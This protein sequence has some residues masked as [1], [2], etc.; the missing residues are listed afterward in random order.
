MELLWKSLS[1]FNRYEISNTGLIFDKQLGKVISQQINEDGYRCVTLRDDLGNRKTF[2]VH[3][4]VA[5]L[6][7]DNP[8]NK[9]TINHKDAVKTNNIWTNLEWATRSENIQHAWD[10]VLIKDMGSRKEGIREHQGRPVV[11]LNDGRRFNSCGEAAEVLK[12]QKSNIHAVC[13]RKK[14]FKSAGKNE[15]GQKLIWRFEDEL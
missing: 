10:N 14:G 13:S 15:K 2:K 5:L 1:D 12:L 9:E 3:R 7:I 8:E 4:L 6:Y 11:C